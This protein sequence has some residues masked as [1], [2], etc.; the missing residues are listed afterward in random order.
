[1][2]D[3]LTAARE[4]MELSL[5]FHIVFAVLGVGMPWLMLFAEWRGLRTGDERWTALAK[6][7]SKAVAVLFAVGAVSGTVLS[8]EFGLLW[9]KF[10]AEFG[11]AIGLSFTLESFAFFIEAIFLALYLY[12]WKRLSPRA[13][14]LTAVPVALGGM[15]SALFVTTA[16]AWM[17]GPVGLVA[18][19][20][21]R[22]VAT[23]PLGPFMAPTAGPQLVHMGF[24]ALMCTGLAV[25][26]VYAV[27]MLRD[28]AKRDGYHRRGLA[29]GAALGL[30]CA[31]LQVLVGD[32]ATRV[33]ADVQPAKFAAME[34]LSHTM[35]GAPFHAGPIE[36]PNALSLLLH[37]D[38]NARVVGMDAIP[39]LDRP[40]IASVHAA[41]Q[42]MA[43]IGTA[44]MALAAWALWLYL[45]HRRGAQH[46]T[47]GR[48]FLL[49][50]ALA[51]PAPFVAL[52]AGWIVTEV[53]RQP[54]I[55]YRVMRVPDALT[56]QTGLAT[57][58][59][60][61]AAVYLVL[62]VALVAILRRIARGPT[63]PDPTTIRL[64]DEVAA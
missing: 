41:F 58:L 60:V 32:W 18:G 6:R 24:A 7:W 4:Q 55:V 26:A 46:P 22:L 56:T 48:G 40:P 53:G 50:M 43:G 15:A 14:L 20:D 61:T 25:S 44:L 3:D 5:S 11:A 45:R 30:A 28:P 21:G 39:P 2:I 42:I 52:I 38:P 17:N 13:H 57:Y 19:P 12:G 54:W 31:P 35:D 37:F 62:A 16:N 36:I 64:K 29:A 63:P 8:I 34:S 1:M 47:R 27:A 49:A 51:G 9:P 59:Y 33:V 23:E 10:M